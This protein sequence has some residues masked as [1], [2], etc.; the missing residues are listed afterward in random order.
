MPLWKFLKQLFFGHSTPTQRP[1]RSNEQKQI[2]D[3]RTKLVPLQNASQKTRLPNAAT[4]NQ[5]PYL[6][7]R[8]E[9][10]TGLWVDLREGG[11]EQFLS[12]EGLP[13]FTTPEELANWLNIKPGRFPCSPRI[14]TKN[15]CLPSMSVSH[16]D[17]D[18]LSVMNLGGFLATLC[19]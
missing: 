8:K 13:N 18:C 17:I 12:Q 15:S 5:K 19:L 3:G 11:D 4:S 10:R 16:A 2:R 6:F 1:S 14:S 7:A 9:P